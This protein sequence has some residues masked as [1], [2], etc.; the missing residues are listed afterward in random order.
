[1]NKLKFLLPLALFV[2]ILMAP[3]GGY[4]TSPQ[5]QSV[6]IGQAAPAS[7]S[8]AQ[9][10]SVGTFWNLNVAA[11]NF[12]QIQ[13][14]TTAP[15][16]A[17]AVAICAN[18]VIN[19][20]GGSEAAGDS[21]LQGTG[22][23]HILSN[24]GTDYFALSGG[25]TITVP[26]T[27]TSSSIAKYASTAMGIT[28][29]TSCSFTSSTRVSTCVRSVAGGYSGTLSGFSATPTCTASYQ[30]SGASGAS[31]AGTIDVVASS[32]TA[33]NVNTY[34]SAGALSDSQHNC[35]AGGACI[36]IVC[37]GV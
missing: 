27:V 6:G 35:G 18:G 19:V 7:P 29:G 30:S 26:T 10:A 20:C 5:F 14:Q 32:S 12:S 8:L 25:N 17:A 9:T 4:P 3:S 37:V 28:A 33:F 24:G 13:A 34:S 15:G 16:T 1:M 11:A 22:T 23:L 2:P 36:Q 21:Q 31:F